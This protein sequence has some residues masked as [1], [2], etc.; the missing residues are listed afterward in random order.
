MFITLHEAIPRT[1]IQP[2]VAFLMAGYP[3]LLK[4]ALEITVISGDSLSIA[5][6]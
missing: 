2:S 5:G 3:K 4:L 1:R 6:L